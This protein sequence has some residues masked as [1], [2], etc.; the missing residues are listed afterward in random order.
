MKKIL[1]TGKNSYIGTSLETVLSRE[2]KKF[3]VDTVD[4]KNSS[5][6]DEDF[7]KYDVIFH[8]AGIAHI[9]ETNKNRE[10]YFQVNTQLAVEVAQKAKLENVKQFIFLSSMSV[11]GVE[12]GVINE[13]TPLKPIGAYGES[14]L[15]AEKQIL[16]LADTEFL[17]AILRPPMVYGEN[18]KGNYQKLAKLAVKMPFFPNYQNFRSMI[19]I[20]NLVFFIK[21]IIQ[22]RKSGIFLPQNSEYV[23]TSEMVRSI[24][25][26]N[27]KRIY[28]TALFNPIIKILKFTTINKVFGNLIYSDS[29][30]EKI[31]F[32][33]FKESINLS[34]KRRVGEQL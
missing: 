24:A 22:K 1:I 21:D 26:N 19:Y 15:L 6:K 27:N 3:Q 16:E 34:E 28:M 13:E 23:S 25:G 17:V 2:P 20:G 11:Y 12:T 33:T 7:S 8:T 4:T 10:L 31:D 18:C 5:W 32:Y 9:K 30:S 14:K 29:I